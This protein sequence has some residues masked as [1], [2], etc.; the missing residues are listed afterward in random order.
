MLVEVLV[1]RGELEEAES[2]LTTAQAD[3]IGGAI[4]GGVL[5]CSRARLR[6]ASG[7]PAT[8]L[9]DLYA[10]GQHLD[11][12]GFTS[13]S[14]V[15]W[16]SEAALAHLALGEPK[17]ARAVAAEELE[18]AREFGTAR[19]IGVALRGVGLVEGSDG[20]EMLREAVARLGDADA[21]LEHARAAT[22]LGASLR[23]AGQRAAAREP[24]RV[25]LELAHLCRATS[26]EDRARIEL[27][28]TGARPRRPLRTG[29]DALT[30][31][32]RRVAQLAAEELTNREIAQALFVTT[33][34]VEGHLTHAF[35]KL[36]VSGRG[37]LAACLGGEG[38][39]YARARS[40]A[41]GSP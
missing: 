19:A 8:A 7:Q 33:R 40:A 13:P 38:A 17:R 39:G 36:D 31:S 37:E 14:V 32:E 29:V 3:G 18:L 22:D 35:Q 25:G 9:A 27:L 24:L 41:P 2:L 5:L 16:R 21:P 34:T 11:A 15:P 20:L 4:S 1:E 23:R 30:P 12:F 6:M 28:A 26:L 10:A